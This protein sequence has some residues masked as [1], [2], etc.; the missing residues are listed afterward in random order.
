ME[1]FE[2]KHRRDYEQN[3]KIQARRN[4]LPGLW[5]AKELG[6]DAAEADAYAKEVIKSEFD[7]PGNIDYCARSIAT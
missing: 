7:E 6:F 5:A 1:S 3:F 4:K 2:E